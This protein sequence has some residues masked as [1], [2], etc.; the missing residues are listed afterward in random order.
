VRVTLGVLILPALAHAQG[1]RLDTFTNTNG[2][3]SHRWSDDGA[4]WSKL[5]EAV[6]SR[7][8]SALM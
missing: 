6:M 7:I 3:L 1:L 4:T 2:I 8:M 5:A